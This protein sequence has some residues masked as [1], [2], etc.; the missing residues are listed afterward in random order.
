MHMVN[1][2]LFKAFLKSRSYCLDL[3]GFSVL[4]LYCICHFRWYN[5]EKYILMTW[6]KA[7]KIRKYVKE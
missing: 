6:R 7:S 2:K 5:K 1:L 4:Q 3:K